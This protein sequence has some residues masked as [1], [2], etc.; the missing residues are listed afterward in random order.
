MSL[1]EK[2]QGIGQTQSLCVNNRLGSLIE[3]STTQTTR[4]AKFA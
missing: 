1:P 3:V 2:G 4:D